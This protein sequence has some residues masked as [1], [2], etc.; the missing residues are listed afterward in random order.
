M[1]KKRPRYAPKTL[2]VTTLRIKK[3]LAD[4]GLSVVS[5][6]RWLGCPDHSLK[7]IFFLNPTLSLRVWQ[8]MVWAARETILRV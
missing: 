4:C 5:Y 2:M 7:C 8:E 6:Q 3:W 1:I